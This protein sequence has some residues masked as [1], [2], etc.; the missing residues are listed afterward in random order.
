MKFKYIRNKLIE[1]RSEVEVDNEIGQFD[2]NKIVE[3]VYMHILNNVYG[4]DLKNANL[5]KENF[6]AIDLIDEENTIV[7]QVT[8][9]TSTTK[10]KNTVEKFENLDDKYSTYDLK[11]FYIK[12]KPK[13]SKSI[14]KEFENV[15][16]L[17]IKDILQEVQANV[18]VCNKL[19]ETLQKM[20][21]DESKSKQEKY[22]KK[23]ISNKTLEELLE[24]YLSTLHKKC[25]SLNSIMFPRQDVPLERIYE[26]LILKS[27]T[28]YE[29]KKEDYSKY[30]DMLI[31]DKLDKNMRLIDTAGMG[32]STV[33]K[34]LVLR[35][36]QNKLHSKIPIFVE[37]RK[38]EKNETL[39]EYIVK[40]MNPHGRKTFTVEMFIMLMEKGK[41][42]F[43]FDGFD[44]VS[45]EK[46]KELGEEISNLSQIYSTN[47]TLLTSREQ[48]YI[49]SLDNQISCTFEPLKLEQ[50]KSLL[51]KYDNYASIEVGKQLI[52]HEN[53]ET[54]NYELFNTPLMVNLLYY[55][56]W[57]NNTIDDNIVTFYNEMFNALFKGH[58]L[59]K[60]GY[61][62]EKVSELTFEKFKTLFNAFS[63]VALFEGKASFK[64]EAEVL[65]TIKN[66]S[67]LSS[68]ELECNEDF[69]T[70]LLHSVP[71][72]T[73]DG[74][75]YKFLHKTIMEFFSAEFLNYSEKSHG[76]FEKIKKKNLMNP[77]NKCF[78]FL[79]EINKSLYIEEVAK[80]FLVEYITFCKKPEYQK[81]NDIFKSVLF[82][83]K[84]MGILIKDYD[85]YT[86]KDYY[87]YSSKFNTGIIFDKKRVTIV[88]NKNLQFNY[89]I[90][91]FFQEITSKLAPLETFRKNHI[92]IDYLLTKLEMNKKYSLLSEEIFE[93]QD[94]K[95]L[96]SILS[97]IM[98]FNQEMIEEYIDIN[99]CQTL[100]DSLDNKLD[101][102]D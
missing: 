43:F 99:K 89:L 38:I 76:L 7:I 19:Y 61:K 48:P 20:F 39:L 62:R 73:R 4:W 101:V 74:L 91:T 77:F 84:N 92:E 90:N 8:S 42:I 46:S 56:F 2:I 49:P 33:S 82:F 98:R 47:L 11:M 12:E 53:F 34:Y 71:L 78:E 15:E 60:A 27:I 51:L 14:L 102:L 31:H 24:K 29:E 86:E 25:Y 81:Y 63:F 3:D 36:L 28:R 66:A 79:Y 97:M 57:H 9:R 13:F 18:D 58:D 83:N 93:L 40:E 95:M 26:P 6:P 59:T 50:I 10:L 94:S 35:V 17:G 87:G 96:Q 5:L 69:L 22:L 67:R 80:D 55:S 85:G 32:K 100:L 54:L 52:A 88:Y 30:I 65:E 64:T 41:F 16:L 45:E 68:I 23:Q 1:L 44:E 21:D 70:D 37:L 75:E 72:L